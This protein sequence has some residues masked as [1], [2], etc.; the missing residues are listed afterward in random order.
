MSNKKSHVIKIS[1]LS[2]KVSCLSRKISCK[3]HVNLLSYIFIVDEYCYMG[4]FK[5]KKKKNK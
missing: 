3:P 5:F 2:R 1:C 4:A